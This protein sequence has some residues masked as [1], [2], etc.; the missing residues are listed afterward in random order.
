[1]ISIPDGRVRLAPHFA[2]SL[3]EVDLVA[4][5]FREVLAAMGH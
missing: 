3:D 4:E 1:M 5:A 2:N